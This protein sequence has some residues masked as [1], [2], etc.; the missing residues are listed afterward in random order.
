MYNFIFSAVSL[1]CS[2]FVVV[3]G[4]G[5][6]SAGFD[7]FTIDMRDSMLIKWKLIEKGFL[8]STVLCHN[9]CTC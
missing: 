3:A 1:F 4:V 2:H 9:W 7:G 6:D 5:L 8:V